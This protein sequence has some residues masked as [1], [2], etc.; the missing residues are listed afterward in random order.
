[1]PKVRVFKPHDFDGENAPPI[2]Q[3]HP[4]ILAEGD[5]WFT[6]GAVPAFN[7]LE[8]LD[9]PSFGGVINLAYPATP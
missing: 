6:L 4:L 1:M 8:Q 7:L 2:E 5:S 3:F 9:F